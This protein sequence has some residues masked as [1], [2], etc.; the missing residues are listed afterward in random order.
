V[1]PERR[2]VAETCRQLS[3]TVG[4]HVEALLWEGGG[5]LN[6]ECQPFPA[7]ITG[8]G[9][10]AVIDE[11]LWR[12]LGGYDV[13]LGM[14]WRRMG[15]PTGGFRS[16]TEAEFRF[17]YERRATSGRPKHILFYARQPRLHDVVDPE[18][19][20]FLSELKGLGLVQ[21]FASREEFRRAVF[22]HLV[23]LVRE[24]LATA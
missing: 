5:P 4:A 12:R 23:A 10:Q 21:R 1:I 24:R 11:H 19:S 9:P 18:T 20:D 15:T 3:L 7:E 6:P 13:Y 8:L 2:I 16:G 22:S 17:A 14:L